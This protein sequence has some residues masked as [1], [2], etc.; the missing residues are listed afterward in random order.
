MQTIKTDNGELKIRSNY[1][2]RP[3]IYWH[4]LTEK[5]Q[6]ELSDYTGALDTYFVRYKGDLLPINDFMAIDHREGIF[7]DFWH[8][9]SPDTFFSG[10]LIHL[11][12]DADLDRIALSCPDDYVIIG[13]YFS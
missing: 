13:E 1:H 8:G 12:N 3:L 10:V 6:A 9:Y 7:P 11:C 2:A 5:E 4:E